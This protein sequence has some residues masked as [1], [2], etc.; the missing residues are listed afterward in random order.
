MSNLVFDF[1]EQ[2]GPVHG[3]KSIYKKCELP[4][5]LS[6]IDPILCKNEYH[7]SNNN[8]SYNNY[9]DNDESY[10]SLVKSINNDGTISPS[11]NI[12]DTPTGIKLDLKSHQKRTLY[13]MVR[14]EDSQYRLS[15]DNNIL[16][17]CDNVGSGKSLE[18]LSLISHRPKVEKMWNNAYYMANNIE[19]YYKRHYAMDGFK[20]GPDVKV[21]SSNLLIVPHNIYHQWM[22]YIKINTTLSVYGI[23]RKSKI[24]LSSK[25]EEL[26][27]GYNI[28]C[29]KSTMFKELDEVISQ[30]FNHN[31]I[32]YTVCDD[33][34]KNA[35]LS[36]DALNS[37]LSQLT[38][39]FVDEFYY[40]KELSNIKNMIAKY[41]ESLDAWENKI[42][43]DHLESNPNIESC[44]NMRKLYK[45]YAF[46]RVIVDEVDSIKIPAFPDVYGKYTWFITSSINN[47][48]Y[49]KGKHKYSNGTK[50]VI[51]TG[52]HGTGFL[53]NTLLKTLGIT[54]AYYAYN[55][56]RVFKTLVRNNLGFIKDS[57]N[58]PSPVT[59]YKMCF[60]PAELNIISSSVSSDVLAAL[61]AGDTETAIELLG[62]GDGSE[63]DI[64][65]LVNK[66]LYKERDNLEIEISSK[67]LQLIQR[68]NEYQELKQDLDIFKEIMQS[69]EEADILPEDTDAL[70]VK[71]TATTLAKNKVVSTQNSIDN[72]VSKYNDVHSKIKGIEER[73]TG[74]DDKQCPICACNVTNP[75]LTVCCQNV[76]CL[77]CLAMAITSSAKKECPL[78]RSTVDINKVHIIKSSSQNQ[79]N[80][81]QE[82]ELPKKL[83]YLV[84]YLQLNSD[85]RIM[86]FSEYGNTFKTIEKELLD[87]SI[88]YS[89]LNGSGYRINNIIN[90]F[91]VGV[92]Q[93]LLLNAKN[94]GAGLNLQFA[95]EILVY[96]RMSKDLEKQVVGR[97]QRMGR[98]KELKITYLCHENEYPKSDIK[99]VTPAQCI[100]VNK[101]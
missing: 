23:D 76:F 5:N 26:L 62:G 29:V 97:A 70:A 68:Q 63:D 59:K 92:F 66:K 60:T 94:F 18:I 47:I 41:R 20:I 36:K 93:V 43:Y 61:N 39:K 17:L 37:L 81:K 45:G 96:H 32:S 48:L 80:K 77:Q 3:L 58:V 8:Y 22:E 33:S 7:N 1:S 51:S 72:F 28:I 75:C 100:P 99:E 85:K 46:Q 71:K 83:E 27:D 4:D 10:N 78:C 55:S 89:M 82:E 79:E 35:F 65:K 21:F 14:R 88:P 101:V 15:T 56:S 24:P 13:E 16:F 50:M 42:N 54:T 19:T 53:K 57:M 67:K 87:K 86:V 9:D 40:C 6:L 52:I 74:C 64:L 69:T 25:I 31:S 34:N 84:N 95:D 11:G 98:T 44:I 49:P 2:Y 73:V 12:I 91:K 38:S 90:N 30:K